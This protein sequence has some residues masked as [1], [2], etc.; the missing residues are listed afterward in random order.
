MLYILQLG[1]IQ[2]VR[3]LCWAISLTLMTVEVARCRGPEPKIFEAFDL[4]VEAARRGA[5]S[6][7]AADLVGISRTAISRWQ[8]YGRQEEEWAEQQADGTIV[9]LPD[10]Y[11]DGVLRDPIY[12]EFHLAMASARAQRQ[13]ECIQRIY[14]AAQ[15][16][17]NWSAA[18]FLLERSDPEHW[19]RKEKLSVAREAGSTDLDGVITDQQKEGMARAVLDQLAI[20]KR[21]GLR[22]APSDTQAESTDMTRR[23]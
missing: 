20:K 12:R 2:L 23:G 15:D 18:A 17:K 22:T 14:E 5:P 8:K 3:P 10:R 19:S 11:E 9:S 16:P 6:R 4:L 21:L 1:Y 7:I 13:I